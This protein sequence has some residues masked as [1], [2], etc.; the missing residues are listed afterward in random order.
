MKENEGTEN[1]EITN[2]IDITENEEEINYILDFLVNK[3]IM[4]NEPDIIED[5]VKQ[6]T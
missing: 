3:K 5:L 4:P 1:I 6:Y 2:V